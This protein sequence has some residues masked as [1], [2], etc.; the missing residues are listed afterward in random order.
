MIAGRHANEGGEV[1]AENEQIHHTPAGVPYPTDYLVGAI[2][3]PQEAERAVQDLEAA[4]FAQDDIVLLRAGEVIQNMR[5]K[6]QH[7]GFFEQMLYPLERWNTQEG[8]HAGRYEQEAL[9]GHAIV[10]VY[11]PEEDQMR[12]ARD[13]LQRHGAHELKHYGKWAIEDF[14]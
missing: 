2:N 5:V 3:D 13:I 6:E 9:K 1:V 7:R 12:R 11:T 4:G 8:L 10:H 14:R